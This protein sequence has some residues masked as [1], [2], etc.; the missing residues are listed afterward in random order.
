MN[1]SDIPNVRF[2]TTKIR[3]GY[4]RDEVDGFIETIR[5]TLQHWEGGRP[6]ELSSEGVVGARFTPTKFRTGYDQGEVDDF[7]DEVSATLIGYESGKQP[8]PS[9]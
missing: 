7:L 3:E 9:A 8:G 2:S 1:S 5:Q 6:G 4:S